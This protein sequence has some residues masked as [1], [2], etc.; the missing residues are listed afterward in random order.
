MTH[1]SWRMADDGPLF[2]LR[3]SYECA[4]R[5]PVDQNTAAYWSLLQ[6]DLRVALEITR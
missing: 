1:Y 6:E 2:S 4:W 5:R 3:R